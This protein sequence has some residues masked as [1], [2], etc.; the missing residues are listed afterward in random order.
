V[1]N[2]LSVTLN[3]LSVHYIVV[4]CSATPPSM[5]IGAAEIDRWHRAPPRRFD[6]IG[7]HHVIRRDGTVEIGRELCDMGAHAVR[8]NRESIGVCLIGGMDK[9]MRVPE[10]NYSVKQFASLDHLLRGYHRAFPMACVVGH[11]DLDSQHQAAKACP[12]F[13]VRQWLLTRHISV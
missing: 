6:R 3:A 7:Y 11:R 8:F 12:C 13:D 5:D 2:R 10:N 9:A 4:H 1:E